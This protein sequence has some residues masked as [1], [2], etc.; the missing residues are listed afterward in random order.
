MPSGEA[1][2]RAIYEAQRQLQ[3]KTCD[4]GDLRRCGVL[5]KA[6]KKIKMSRTSQE[7]GLNI[8]YR[9]VL[10]SAHFQ[11]TPSTSWLCAMRRRVFFWV[12]H[13]TMDPAVG[14][15]LDLDPLIHG[16]ETKGKTGRN[17]K[18]I[19][20][21][22]SFCGPRHR[23]EWRLC[24]TLFPFLTVK[25]HWLWIVEIAK[26]KKQ[27]KSL[28]I[29]FSQG[30]IEINDL[31]WK[32]QKRHLYSL[33]VYNIGKDHIYIYISS[34]W[35]SHFRYGSSLKISLALLKTYS[36]HL[37]TFWNLWIHVDWFYW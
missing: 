4:F 31:L 35:V 18:Q 27:V 29:K 1:G 37:R 32:T 7:E 14:S 34:N 5:G 6:H 3:G 11:F 24:Q 30:G 12:K 10:F 19:P 21:D 23:S 28:C 13:S 36:R 22:C 17:H 25:D 33:N 2:R 26:N 9:G 20:A 8:Q 16:M 15:L